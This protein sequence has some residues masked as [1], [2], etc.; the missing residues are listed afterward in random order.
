[1]T[2]KPQTSL[3]TSVPDPGSLPK[4]FA[5]LDH[6]GVAGLVL[7]S[8]AAKFSLEHQR[9]VANALA[10]FERKGAASS[11]P[12]A[13]EPAKASS[14]LC[15]EHYCSRERS[16]GGPCSDGALVP[17]PR[18]GQLITDG[19]TTIGAC[20]LEL[21]HAGWCMRGV[22]PEPAKASGWIP[23][24]ERL[25]ED[26]ITRLVCRGFRTVA[27]YENGEWWRVG[28]NG[29]P[30]AFPGVTHWMPLPAPPDSEEK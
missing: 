15:E 17:P 22:K 9:K 27:Y 6:F 3:W 2:D 12:E 8:C 24:S 25:P 21:R 19:Q 20:E 28:S 11:V 14:M 26:A 7:K 30:E 5:E 16:H 29:K 23:V 10:Y 18:C 13:P 1:M 4:E